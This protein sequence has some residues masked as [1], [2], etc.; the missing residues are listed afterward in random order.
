[1]INYVKPY[2]SLTHSSEKSVSKKWRPLPSFKYVPIT[3]P[4]PMKIRTLTFSLFIKLQYSN[5]VLNFS[6]I[7]DAFLI[8]VYARCWRH[9]ITTLGISWWVPYCRMRNRTSYLFRTTW[10][11]FKFLIDFIILAQHLC[12]FFFFFKF[13][14]TKWTKKFVLIYLQFY[15]E[16]MK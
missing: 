12:E 14:S 13:K 16:T 15:F 5:N 10:F 3:F 6:L 11:H 9:I 1:M 8:I 7:D 2:H 4:W